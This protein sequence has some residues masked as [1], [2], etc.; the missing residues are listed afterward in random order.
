MQNI[1]KEICI[2]WKMNFEWQVLTA[3]HLKTFL[4]MKLYISERTEGLCAQPR[5]TGSNNC[6]YFSI[7]F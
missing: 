5:Y 7:I 4:E 3:C 6:I 2:F 1:E